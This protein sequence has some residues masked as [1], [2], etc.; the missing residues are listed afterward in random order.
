M[1]LE[2]CLKQQELLYTTVVIE[3]TGAKTIAY[4]S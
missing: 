1:N 3:E 4:T 2:S